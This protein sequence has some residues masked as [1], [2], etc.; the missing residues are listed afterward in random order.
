VGTAL[1]KAPLPDDL[2]S[3]TARD[4]PLNRED[5][6][7]R[8][9]EPV[10]DLPRP[11]CSSVVEKPIRVA[12]WGD[13]HALAWQPFAWAIADEDGVAATSFTRDACAPALDYDNGK[14]MLEADRCKEFNRSVVAKL[15]AYDTIV[16]TA[17]WPQPDHG[18]FESHFTATLTQVASTARRVIVIGQTPNL[19]D[20]VPN[21]IARGALSAC[22]VS[23]AS[24]DKDAVPVRTMLQR[25]AATHSNVEYVDVADFFCSQVNCLALKDGYGLYWDTN[26]VSSTAARMFALNYI[27]MKGR[28]VAAQ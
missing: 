1:Y 16:I 15:R 22:D 21:C 25:V 11:G 17:W 6:N 13:S 27:K 9:D 2:A 3:R 5:C 18:D 10:G 8:G 20:S 7:S 28:R 23:R 19:P 4:Q 24:F 14:R 26:H 12:I